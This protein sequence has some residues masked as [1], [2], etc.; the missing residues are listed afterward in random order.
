MVNDTKI[1]KL[2][3]KRL[4]CVLQQIKEEKWRREQEPVI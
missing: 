1:R 4:V 3:D 2:R